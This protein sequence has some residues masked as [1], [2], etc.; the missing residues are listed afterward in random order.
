MSHFAKV[1]N[2]VVTQVIVAEQG[3]IDQLPDKDSW[4]QTSYNT[5][6]NVHF[7]SEMETRTFKT[8]VYADQS[9]KILPDSVAVDSTS[10]YVMGTSSYTTYYADDGVAL[11]GNFAGIGH[12]YDLEHDVFYPPKPFDSWVI[13]AST[14]WKWIPPVRPVGDNHGVWHE[15]SKSWLYPITT[16]DEDLPDFI[17]WVETHVTNPQS[18]CS[19]LLNSD[20]NTVPNLLTLIAHSSNT[21]STQYQYIIPTLL[22]S[23]Y[24]EVVSYVENI[25]AD[26]GTYLTLIEKITTIYGSTGTVA[27]PD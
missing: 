23:T 16:Q 7:S 14:N 17:T 6:G 5:R 21:T 2:G 25:M 15:P 10:T 4:I 26:T 13:D 12:V 22:N 8:V 24:T 11:R 19:F 3:F 20:F 1:E 27:T 18:M 9:V